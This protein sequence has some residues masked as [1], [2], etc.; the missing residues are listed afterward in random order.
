MPSPMNLAICPPICSSVFAQIVWN[1]RMTSARSSGSSSPASA[2]EP[3][4]SQNIT[5]RCRRSA[6]VPVGREALADLSTDN[7][8]LLKVRLV[9][10]SP[11]NL[12]SAGFVLPQVG[13][14]SGNA[15]PH[16]PQNLLPSGLMAPQ[17][18]QS[19]EFHRP[20]KI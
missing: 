8:L 10:Q 4:R 14:P 9:P 19:I 5:V 18:G 2:V 13:Q 6:S 12:D 11:Q 3:T 20:H 7:P 15:E 16:C 1:L 17:A